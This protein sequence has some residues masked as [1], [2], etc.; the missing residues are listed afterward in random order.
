MKRIYGATFACHLRKPIR[1]VC[2]TKSDSLIGGNLANRS[3]IGSATQKALQSVNKLPVVR[4]ISNINKTI[5][6][7]TA[8]TSSRAAAS[9][10]GKEAKPPT[11]WTRARL[12]YS[13]LINRNAGT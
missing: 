11:P 13:V 9:D 10:I 4:G 2:Q 3:A 8:A 5:A 6:L 12:A 7:A 1:S